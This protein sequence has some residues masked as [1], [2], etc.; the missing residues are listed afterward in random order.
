M[1][2]FTL[3][4]KKKKLSRSI[5]RRTEELVVIEWRNINTLVSGRS[6]SQLRQALIS[7]DKTLDNVLRDLV[8]GETM[9]DRLKNSESKFDRYSYDKI[10]KAHKLRN[11]L[12]HESGFEPPHY[13]LTEA[14]EDLRRAV[15]SLGIRV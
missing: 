12:V 14:I 5:S 15:V 2:L 6:P 3:F 7:A 13:V 9:G 10:W 8:D 1:N 11:T 4:G